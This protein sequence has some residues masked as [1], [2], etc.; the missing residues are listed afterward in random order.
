LRQVGLALHH[1]HDARNRF[2]P[3]RGTPTPYIFSAQA[4]LLPFVEENGLSQAINFAAPPASFTVPPTT[5]YDGSVNAAAAAVVPAVLVCPSDGNDGRVP[6]LAFGGTNYV[7]CAGSGA[8]EGNLSTTDGVFFLGSKT[9]FQ[10]V[11]DGASMTAAFSERTLGQGTSAG[12]MPDLKRVM[13]EISPSASPTPANCLAGA[14]NH[15]RSGKWIV[16]NYGNTLYNHALP[17]NPA[18]LDCMTGTQQKARAA[19]RS[20]HPGGVNVA[21]CDGSLR[22]VGN[23][24][25]LPAWQDL[26]TRAGGEVVLTEW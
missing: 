24:I 9:G 12:S 3:G 7:G 20:N 21:F 2:P 18:D 19:A 4:F 26:S 11:L 13:R 8:S 6:G 17:P 25:V 10:S 14:W 15:E 23:S 22:F 1:H 16:G 5:V